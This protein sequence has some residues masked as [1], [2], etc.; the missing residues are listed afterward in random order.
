MSKV[1]KHKAALLNPALKPCGALIGEWKTI[2]T[3][4]YL[5]DSILHG[6]SSFEWIQGGAFILWRSKM[7]EK[8]FPEGIAIF[9]SDDATGEFFVLYFDDRNVSRKYNVSFDGDV[10]KLWRTAPNFSQR[11]TWT[12]ADDNNSIIQK[13]E[14]CKDGSTWE[15]DLEL[16]YMRVERADEK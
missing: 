4:P 10:I 13:G 12:F 16:T 8:K 14:M 2:G 15:K 5:P 3:H 7:D 1:S 6:R 11:F 9:G